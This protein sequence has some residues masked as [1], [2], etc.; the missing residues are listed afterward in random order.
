[1]RAKDVTFT[2]NVFADC[3]DG[4][5]ITCYPRAASV[6][7]FAEEYDIEYVFFVFKWGDCDFDG[8]IT[9]R[10]AAYILQYKAAW[11]V[12]MDFEAADADGDGNITVR[13]AARILQYKAGWN[14]SLG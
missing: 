13:D 6:I 12:M 3:A 11:H 7:S 9:M 8:N 5:V 1:M 2:E 4:L 14:V 10:D